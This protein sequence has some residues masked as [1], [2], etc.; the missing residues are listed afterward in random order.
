MHSISLKNTTILCI[1]RNTKLT[2]IFFRHYCLFSNVVLKVL[3]S[4][5]GIL[6][7]VAVEVANKY[8]KNRFS[9]RALTL[10]LVDFRRLFYVQT[11]SYFCN[12]KRFILWC[13]P[14]FKSSTPVV[15]HDISI[16]Y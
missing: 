1:L 6:K 7:V 13:S 9:L 4:H 5:R 10:S 16:T 2:S 8:G 15:F 3:S 14:F 12:L 11:K